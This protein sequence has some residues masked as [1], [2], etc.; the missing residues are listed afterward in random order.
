M[1]LPSLEIPFPKVYLLNTQKERH[2]APGARTEGFYFLFHAFHASCEFLI[3]LPHIS[4]GRF[5]GF[6]TKLTSER[7]HLKWLKLRLPILEMNEHIHLPASPSPLCAV[8]RVRPLHHLCPWSLETGKKKSITTFRGS[9]RQA[10]LRVKSVKSKTK[11]TEDHSTGESPACIPFLIP[12]C[13]LWVRF[14]AVGE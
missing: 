3:S 6:A 14:L 1:Y 12:L 5:Q 13:M 2:C 10:C 8:L 9:V 4:S 11:Q 7:T